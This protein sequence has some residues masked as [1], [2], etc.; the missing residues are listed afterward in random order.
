MNE[1]NNSIDTYID[2]YSKKELNDYDKKIILYI[3]EKL[4]SMIEYMC[5]NEDGFHITCGIVTSVFMLT[6]FGIIF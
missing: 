4:N 6:T 3:D 2:T 5:E 1:I